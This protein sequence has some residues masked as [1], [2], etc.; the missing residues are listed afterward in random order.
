MGLATLQGDNP[1][2]KFYLMGGG[3]VA[4]LSKILSEITSYGSS[5]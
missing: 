4:I 5:H 3:G 2:Q 1:T